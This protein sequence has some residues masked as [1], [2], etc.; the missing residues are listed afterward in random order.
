[1][2]DYLVRNSL[3]TKLGINNH[4]RQFDCTSNTAEFSISCYF[5][6]LKNEDTRSP[7]TETR[8]FGNTAAGP[9]IHLSLEQRI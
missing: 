6:I 3:P 2:L 8:F 4:R 5:P 1:L 7:W 9:E